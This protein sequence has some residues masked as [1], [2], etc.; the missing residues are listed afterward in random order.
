M[1]RKILLMTL[2]MMLLLVGHSF[3]Q[4]ETIDYSIDTDEAVVSVDQE[5]MTLAV[6]EG[7]K[8]EGLKAA[9][10]VSTS[11]GAITLYHTSG[12]AIMT[13]D[14]GPIKDNNVLEI[15]SGALKESYIIH[16]VNPIESLDLKF[17][18]GHYEFLGEEAIFLKANKT[19]E[20]EVI[21]Y[22]RAGNKVPVD[23]AVIDV[24][25]NFGTDPIFEEKDGKY[26]LTTAHISGGY[27]DYFTGKITV[28]DNAY[29]KNIS[30]NTY[31]GKL[32][33]LELND[34]NDN[35]YNGWVNYHINY[36]LD[37]GSSGSSF[38][39]GSSSD[40]RAYKG[41][42]PI[43]MQDG[44]VGVNY[45]YIIAAPKHTIA[46]ANTK[47]VDVTDALTELM[48]VESVGLD[49]PAV[50]QK[51]EFT[52]T[53]YTRDD[54]AWDG[55][56][57][58]FYSKYDGEYLGIDFV[59]GPAAV[60]GNQFVLAGLGEDFSRTF[61]LSIGAHELDQISINE[62]AVAIDDKTQ[63]FKSP[64]PAVIGK[65]L[66][67]D[68]G[69]KIINGSG[70]DTNVIVSGDDRF[71]YNTD[72]AEFLLKELE[73]NRTYQIYAYIE[74]G[75][76]YDQKLTDTKK[77]EFVYDDTKNEIDLTSVH[78]DETIT[79]TKDESTGVYELNLKATKSIL[80][81]RVFKGTK[82]SPMT[83]YTN[84]SLY[85]A[86]GALVS[87]SYTTSSQFV[88]ENDN[89]GYFMLGGRTIEPGTYY[90][91]VDVPIDSIDYSDYRQKVKLPLAENET[92]NIILPETKI[93][94]NIVGEGG[95]ESVRNVYVNI[96]DAFGNYIKNGRVRAD[97]KFAVGNLDAGKYY[98][99][100]FV[101]PYSD[102]SEEYT[103]SKKVA[104]EVVKDE[105][106]N[107]DVPLT[108]KMYS[109]TLM[110]ATGD[111]WIRIF[112]AEMNTVEAVKSNDNGKFNLPLLD[113]GEYFIKAYGNNKFDSILKPFTVRAGEVSGLNDTLALSSDPSVQI[114]LVNDAAA[115]LDGEVIV[116]DAN[117]KFLTFA[118]SDAGQVA[119]GGLNAGTY[120]I[121]VKPFDENYTRSEFVEITIEDT[122]KQTT[123]ELS[124]ASIAGTINAEAGWVY[125]LR[126]NTIV[127]TSEIVKGNF[128]LPTLQADVTYEVYAV[129][130]DQEL[131]ETARKEITSTTESLD[132][133]ASNVSA[134]RGS[135]L[136]DD[137]AVE[138]QI[139]YLYDGANQA[140]DSVK[141][142]IFGGFYFNNIPSGNYKLVLP[143]QSDAII[144]EVEYSNEEEVIDLTL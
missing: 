58:D 55:I 129:P 69:E 144:E 100:V 121:E 131:Y 87:R 117:K 132:L 72:N 11:P 30:V 12:G 15:S 8:V 114:N 122:F 143:T 34:F 115:A 65:L 138:G 102:L 57:G 43:P 88:D 95:F 46:M 116:Y 127:S 97:G 78:G 24:G 67:P 26:S 139:V 13:D 17:I 112:D 113:D 124:E 85:D 59:S 6:L 68:T 10:N 128:S 40:G 103:S 37:A 76:F 75:D 2:V 91:E 101:S 140:V 86:Q 45:A 70:R 44:Y 141:T 50:F 111:N 38:G 16:V 110:K 48:S 47:F 20:V 36:A 33:L 28:N 84:V 135:V 92:L 94:G 35:P 118:E 27:G 25:S 56:F 98:S 120:F 14:E 22:N 62:R 107:F 21:A 96:F 137:K 4:S 42:L 54:A 7:T 9:V 119:I 99:K 61:E 80:R 63:D 133:V 71:E 19:Y 106:V 109:G 89:Q 3:S 93:H 77:Y 51:P 82:N 74:P 104:F 81:G 130:E 31:K 125:L 23:N 73:N 66:D 126:D 142:D 105:K 79:M 41:V 123:V 52:G 108:Q 90:V 60:D 136:K 32:L 1:K 134:I 64:M 29:Q 83:T 39:T 5:N 53:V 18:G 49:T